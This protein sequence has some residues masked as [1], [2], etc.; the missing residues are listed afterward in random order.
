LLAASCNS[1]IK[2]PGVDEDGLVTLNV[3]T[4]GA[5]GN[6]RSL[7]AALAHLGA[8]YMEV[9]FKDGTKYY[10]AKGDY[11]DNYPTNIK[12]KVPA[13]TVG[14]EKTYDDTNAI[15]L[16]GR[17]SDGTLL[18]TGVPTAQIK[19]PGD[20]AI[21]FSVTSLTAN[22]SAVG[23]SALTLT[24]SNTTGGQFKGNSAKPSFQVPY[25]ATGIT[26][27]LNIGGLASQGGTLT[28]TGANIYPTAVTGLVTF[29]PVFGTPASAGITPTGY[30]APTAT[31]TAIGA[32]S[33][34]IFAFNT[35]AAPTPDTDYHYI[36][37]FDI[38]VVGF[39]TLS[40]PTDGAGSAPITWHIRGGTQSGT[41]FTGASEA[42]GIPLIVTSDP[43]LQSITVNPGTLP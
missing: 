23:T 15:I 27:T 24:G 38:P 12:V 4:G 35:P 41:D 16:I 3:N 32:S 43:S 14:S 13:G 19:V 8:D 5:A 34:L 11:Y 1:G 21:T 18:A 33:Q 29:Y 28:A 20:S 10:R 37:T 25:G 2:T 30:T 22:I 39:S 36:I 40:G 31:A 17:E 42:E 26:A 7:T 6:S 9:V